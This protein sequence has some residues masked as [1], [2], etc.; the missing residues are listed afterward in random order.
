VYWS[1]VLVCSYRQHG[2]YQYIVEDE[3]WDADDE[4]CGSDTTLDSFDSVPLSLA[5]GSKDDD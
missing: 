3:N 1:S 4:D 2:E 5:L